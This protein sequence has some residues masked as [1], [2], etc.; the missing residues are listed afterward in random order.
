MLHRRPS[1]PAEILESPSRNAGAF[2]FLPTSVSVFLCRFESQSALQSAIK[3]QF[4]A[5]KAV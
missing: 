5:L 4:R 1:H 3:Y 2:L